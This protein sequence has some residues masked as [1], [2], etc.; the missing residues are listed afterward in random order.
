MAF[1]PQYVACKNG[2]TEPEYLIPELEP[3]LKNTFGVIVYQEQVIRIAQDL[4]GFSAGAADKFRKA[5]GKKNEKLIKEQIDL[6]IHGNENDAKAKKIIPGLLKNGI[7]YDK[8]VELG[9]RIVSFAKYAFNRSHSAG[10]AV[11]TSQT[12]YL[13][14]HYTLEFLAPLISSY[15]GK[16]SKSGEE[17]KISYYINKAKASK[18][19]ILPPDI[20]KSGYEFL[21][22]DNAIRYGLGA[23][24]GLNKS[25]IAI[26]KEREANGDFTSIE[27]FLS[28]FGKREVNKKTIDSLVLSGALDSVSKEKNR[29]KILET[30][31]ELRGDKYD[32]DT[33][34]KFISEEIV[35][36]E[37]AKQYFDANTMKGM[38]SDMKQMRIEQALLGTYISG[39]PLDGVAQSIDWEREECD[40]N[41]FTMIGIISSV[42]KIKTRK[43]DDMAFVQLE[44][45]E[46]FKDITL[47]PRDYEL[48]KNKLDIGGIREITVQCKRRKDD[49]SQTSLIVKNIKYYRGENNE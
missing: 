32:P 14:A 23:I 20:N 22:E 24:K 15:I 41:T 13:K 7:P 48:H 39:H 26:V 29:L 10:Y 38:L 16:A 27:D 9:R 3:I 17:D 1:I 47:F 19:T 8:A 33:I 34:D 43:K 28:R 6:L 44:V 5:V 30:I 37:G 21:L 4:A 18:I 25:A 11:I 12:A 2:Y 35:N 31:Y 45:L 42:K 40:G 49:P 46:G 36:V